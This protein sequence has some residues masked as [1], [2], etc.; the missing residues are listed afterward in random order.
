[1]ANE[2][3]K[4]GFGK[5]LRLVLWVLW[6]SLRMRWL[7]NGLT[8]LAV[9][10][11]VGLAL[12]VP[13]SVNSF[14]RGAV[15]ASRIFDLLVTAEGS[16]TQVVLNSIY[17][18]SAPVGNIPYRVYES[19]ANDPRTARAVPLGFGDNYAGYPLVGTS[20]AYFDL[21]TSAQAPPYYQLAEGAAFSRP[22]QAVVGA[23][24]A[25]E[26]G[27]SLGDTFQ[28]QHGF[29]AT[30]DPITHSFDYT[31][32]GILEPTGGPSDR[33]IY[34]AIAS[35]WE[36]HG[37]YSPTTGQVDARHACAHVRAGPVETLS[38]RD[39]PNNLSQIREVHTRYDSDVVAFNG[40][41]GGLFEL[42]IGEASPYAFYVTSDVILSVFG[43]EGRRVEPELVA[44]ERAVEGCDEV[45]TAHVFG[46][47]PAT[48][49]VQ[50]N[51]APE[52]TMSFVFEQIDIAQQ[53]TTILY[54]STEA[55]M[56]SEDEHDD[57]T[58][59]EGEVH[60]DLDVIDAEH[61]CVHMQA[62][63]VDTLTANVAPVGMEAPPSGIHRRLDISLRR[64]SESYGGYFTYV[65]EEDREEEDREFVF[66]ADRRVTVRHVSETG[67][68]T[69][70]VHLF[71]GEAVE[72][73]AE[74]TE[75]HVFLLGAGEHQF[76]V[77]GVADEMVRLVVELYEHDHG[78]HEGE[79]KEGEEHEGDGAA[80]GDGTDGRGTPDRN[81]IAVEAL[82]DAPLA[83]GSDTR[84]VTAV[85]YA[86]ES[87]GDLYRIASYLDEIQ[88][89]Q[90]VFP[91]AVLNQLIN[92]VGQ[93]RE[94]YGLLANVILALAIITVALNTYAN[95]LQ[96][97]KTLAILRAVGVSRSVVAGSVLL[98]AALLSLFGIALGVA[99]AYVGT[100][101]V[102]DIVAAHASITLPTPEMSQGDWLRALVLLPV[103]VLFAVLPALNAARK[104]PLERL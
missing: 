2:T 19:L 38:L 61:A 53:D 68:T 13:M 56:A 87:L 69:T 50:V 26:T 93:G 60:S 103:A 30:F 37:Q 102:G 63:P 90:A 22:F 94:V 78:E 47:E 11:G 71:R 15:D 73:C 89:V 7:A 55:G 67:S 31:V 20:P 1:M 27:L 59:E 18:Q 49:T 10:L 91:G 39:S 72:S 84:D 88:G 83:D 6:R 16:E 62:G 3:P 104:S 35:L 17:Y 45:V 57:Y 99:A 29:A 12:V 92:L 34:T 54:A 96:A 77:R 101:V 14:Q 70:P 75:A 24:V 4:L 23:F 100:V 79:E 9:L 40:D 41:R 98:E 43:P 51:S 86:S 21:R 5:R 25:Q 95:A 80:A 28:T 97:Q 8:V 76:A 85:L 52:G 65:A 66:F 42:V 32:V 36:A 58:G 64:Q 74:I 46:L 81:I 33:A 44:D 48:Y 82:A